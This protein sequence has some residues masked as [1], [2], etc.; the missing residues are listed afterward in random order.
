MNTRIKKHSSAPNVVNRIFCD[1]AKGGTS[2]NSKNTHKKIFELKTISKKHDQHY[3][4][5]F[6]FWLNI[7]RLIWYR[8]KW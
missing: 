3:Y 2:N 5:N 7:L 4:T 1:F 6:N 8:F